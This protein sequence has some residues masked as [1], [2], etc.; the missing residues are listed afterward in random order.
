MKTKEKKKEK[1]KRKKKNKQPHSV[2]RLQ[3]V[4]NSVSEVLN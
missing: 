2:S 3:S 1:K 4:K